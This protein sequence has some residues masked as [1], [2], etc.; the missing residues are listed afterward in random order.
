MVGNGAALALAAWAVLRGRRFVDVGAGMLLAVNAMLSVTD[1]LGLA[2]LAALALN[3]AT[4]A[5]LAVAVVR[6]SAPAERT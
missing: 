6:G 1:Q 3:L 4:L 5:L 2:D